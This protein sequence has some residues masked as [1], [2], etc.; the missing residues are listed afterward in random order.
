MN[1][2]EASMQSNFDYIYAHIYFEYIRAYNIFIK[3]ELGINHQ[4][5]K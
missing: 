1:T 2:N 3:V 4:M 5:H